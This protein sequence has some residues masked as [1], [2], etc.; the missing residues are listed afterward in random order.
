MHPL[1]SHTILVQTL[2]NLYKIF[3][4][5]TDYLHELYR[6]LDNFAPDFYR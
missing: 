5:H 6:T 1:K 2:L 3:I 4:P